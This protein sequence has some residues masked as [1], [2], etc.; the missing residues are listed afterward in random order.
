MSAKNDPAPKKPPMVDGWY[1]SDAKFPVKPLERLVYYARLAP[2]VFNSQ[3][4]KFV[5][6]S[7]DIDVFADFERWRPAADADKREL[8]LS[9]GCAIESLRVAADFAGW[10]TEVSY[11]PVEGD[12]TLVARVRVS[13]TGPKRDDAAAD[14]LSRMV[15]R[16]TSHRLFDPAR[17]VA[18]VDRKRL[19][20][21]FEI[22]DVSLHFL[23]DRLALDA[24]AAVENR[25][26]AALLARPDYRAEHAKGVGAG[27]L[28]SAWTL[29]KL[30]QFALAHLPL[31]NQVT[32]NDA[33]R[34]ASAP[35]VAL[36]TTRQ[37]RRIDQMQA[38]QAFM[39]LAL[40]AES[41]DI[42]V[43]P[44]SQVLE[45]AD[46]RA[47]VARIFALGE[48]VAQHMFRL[49]YADKEVRPYPRRPMDEI[50]VGSR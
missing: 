38:G 42:R 36:L 13:L 27:S 23:N 4:W 3:P 17:P 20:Q 14:L 2:S 6:G 47:E 22:G 39:R 44:V 45:V 10:G 1:V 48:R 32:H 5:V 40:V 31:G 9:L 35:L 49:G 15:T 25:A 7:A 21:C 8:H 41:R 34:L 43:Q 11:L 26:D 24:L 37:D 28:G 12:E 33:E 30:G 50:L 18:D 19:Y 29:S 46:A 16:H